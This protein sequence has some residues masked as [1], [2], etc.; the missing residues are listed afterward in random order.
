VQKSSE[1]LNRVFQAIFENHT[2]VLSS[3]T[4]NELIGTAKRKFPGQISV[5]DNVLAHMPYMEKKSKN[6]RF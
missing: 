5:I 1:H 2:L 6:P 3:Y 4:I